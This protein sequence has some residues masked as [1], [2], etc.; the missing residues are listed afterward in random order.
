MLIPDR[1]YKENRA[2]W[3]TDY[4]QSDNLKYGNAN[5]S[6][7]VWK[8]QSPRV[9][10]QSNQS[11]QSSQIRN[12]RKVSAKQHY[13]SVARYVA[14]QST[15]LPSRYKKFRNLV[16]SI[17][18]VCA[19]LII[20][21]H[22]IQLHIIEDTY[23]YEYLV[24][25]L[26]LLFVNNHIHAKR[27]YDAIVR[28]LINF[29]IHAMQ[30]LIIVLSKIFS[31]LHIFLNIFNITQLIDCSFW[32]SIDVRLLYLCRSFLYDLSKY[33]SRCFMTIINLLDQNIQ[34][35]VLCVMYS[36]RYI[37]TI[38]VLI[39]EFSVVYLSHTLDGSKC[40]FNGTIFQN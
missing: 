1:V 10:N 18:I 30:Y 19:M 22:L 16:E 39:I 26:R 17:L 40:V 24:N 15:N 35:L 33:L 36:L 3:N 4:Q 11:N 14:G 27:F 34:S 29:L 12:S 5:W 31:L 8:E 6:L 13:L 38:F 2:N 25:P 23:F 21:R 9:W 28:K 32:F 37:L 20:G 7:P